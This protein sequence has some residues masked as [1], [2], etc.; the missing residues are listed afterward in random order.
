MKFIYTFFVSLL[1]FFSC[2]KKEAIEASAK[3][4]SPIKKY[5]LEFLFG[6]CIDIGRF[7]NQF[8]K[9]LYS[10]SIFFISSALGK[11]ELYL[12]GKLISKKNIL[13]G[14]HLLILSHIQVNQ[15]VLYWFQQ[16]HKLRI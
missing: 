5:S 8:S 1:L 10:D 15:M 13:C 6:N 7:N 16:R 14:N 3:K 9:I 11:S 2:Q 4:N 12:K